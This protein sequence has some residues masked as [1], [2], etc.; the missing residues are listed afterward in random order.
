MFSY[1]VDQE[2]P[3]YSHLGNF[4]LE[5]N[6]IK[7]NYL[8]SWGAQDEAYKAMNETATITINDDGSLSLSE[9]PGDVQD[10]TVNM[11][12]VTGDKE[13]QLLAS[14]S[15]DVYHIL[16]ETVKDFINKN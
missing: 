11:T 4:I 8:M 12:K 9:Q 5:D 2:G 10:E 1:I 3:I 14:K 6:K 16:N 7:L 13:Q 15:F